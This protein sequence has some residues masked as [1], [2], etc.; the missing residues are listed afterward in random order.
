MDP[1]WLVI[2]AAVALFVARTLI[3]A[4]RLKAAASNPALADARALRDAKRDLRANR[5]HLEAAL[6]APG[7]HLEAAK[8]LSRGRPRA[9]AA[10]RV[11]RMVEDAF[12][13]RRA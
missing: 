7:D 12:S 1:L 3:I 9:H 8:R 13:E 11:G 6:A 5:T 10:S 4:R 2:P